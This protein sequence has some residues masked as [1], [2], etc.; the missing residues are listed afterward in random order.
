MWQYERGSG[1]AARGGI[2]G[3]RCGL[4]RAAVPNYVWHQL[5]WSCEEYSTVCERH[6]TVQY[7]VTHVVL[8]HTLHEDRQPLGNFNL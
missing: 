3:G 8:A 5:S 4:W 7:S 6:S 2:V 1:P